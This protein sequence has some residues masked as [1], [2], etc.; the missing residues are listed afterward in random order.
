MYSEQESF[1][2]TLPC[3]SI[4][5]RSDF[6]LQQIKKKKLLEKLKNEK[7]QSMKGST[8]IIDKIKKQRETYESKLGDQKDKIIFKQQRLVKQLDQE[9]EQ[10]A[11]ENDQLRTTLCNV[12]SERDLLA[13]KAIELKY[14]T[15]S[16]RDQLKLSQAHSVKIL[17]DLKESKQDLLKI[18]R[19][20][21]CKK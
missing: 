21:I 5:Q 14:Q 18:S 4:N 11:K 9:N 8:T 6:E 13:D 3:E 7:F 16:L 10:L 19:I 1:L 20:S 17:N 2:Q 15:D 12:K